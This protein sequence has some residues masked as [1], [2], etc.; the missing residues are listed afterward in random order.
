M[1]R[2]AMKW[3]DEVITAGIPKEDI[4]SDEELGI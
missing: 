1:L 3:E 2:R 4:V